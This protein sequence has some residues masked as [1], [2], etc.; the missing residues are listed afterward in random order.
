MPLIPSRLQALAIRCSKGT[1]GTLAA[2]SLAVSAVYFGAQWRQMHDTNTAVAT[3][4]LDTAQELARGDELQ[5][6]IGYQS[7]LADELSAASTAYAALRA[8]ENSQMW[9]AARYNLAGIYLRQ[10]VQLELA[11]KQDGRGVLIELAKMHYR[12]LL[13]DKPAHTDA[14]NNLA[15]AL[16]LQPDVMAAA[17]PDLDEMPERS[18]QS[19]VAKEGRERLP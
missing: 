3:Q 18:P 13:H 12:K 4:N 10:A 11:E 8:S 7:D 2:V 6:I 19:K 14:A 17:V 16:A 9:P 1:P 5:F 15:W